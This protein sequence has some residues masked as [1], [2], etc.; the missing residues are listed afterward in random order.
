MDDLGFRQGV[1]AVERLRS[2][3]GNVFRLQEH[4]AR[5][6]SSIKAMRI[7]AL[8]SCSQIERIVESLVDRNRDWIFQQGEFGVTIVATPGPQGRSLKSHQATFAVHLN[9]LDMHRIENRIV[10]GQPLVVTDVVQPPPESWP[11]YV[12]SRC[13]LHYHLA[14]QIARDHHQNAIGVLIDSDETITETSICNVAI[15]EN[16][17]VISPPTDRILSGVTQSVVESLAQSIGIAWKKVPLSVDRF[18]RADEI[19][20]MGT[21]TGLW[22][23]NSVGDRRLPPLTETAVCRRLQASFRSHVTTG[24]SL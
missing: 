16:G 9:S 19:L 17:S 12:K 4:L 22:F 18:V 13:R 14:D 2:Y 11:R 24:R 6:E 23:A 15:V 10:D 3:S 8:P 5:W 1:V 20:L 7:T 21:D